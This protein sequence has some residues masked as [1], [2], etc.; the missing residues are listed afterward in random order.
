MMSSKTT[1]DGHR[2]RRRFESSAR[3]QPRTRGCR[4]SLEWRFT[5]VLHGLGLDHFEEFMHPERLVKLLNFHGTGGL[6]VAGGGCVYARGRSGDRRQPLATLIR[7]LLRL[8]PR[9]GQKCA[10][11]TAELRTHARRDADADFERLML[12]LGR[13]AR[14]KDLRGRD[15]TA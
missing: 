12:V 1:S 15:A 11:E 14:A 9:R 2:R 4:L 8:R 6:V 10:K 7:R 5:P 13:H 3:T